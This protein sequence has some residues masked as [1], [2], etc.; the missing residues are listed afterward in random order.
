MAAIA[1][2]SARL[3]YR[4]DIDGLRAVAVLAVL[5]A[6]AGMPGVAGGFLGVDVFFVI[7]GYLITLILKNQL[8]R[9]TLSLAAFYERRA[10]RIVPALIPVMMVSAPLGV[11]LMLPEFRQNFGQSLVA[12]SLFANNLLLTVTSGYWELESSFKPLLHTWSLGVE[13]Q[14]Y[15]V[16]PILLALVWKRGPRAQ[17]ALIA[18]IGAASFVAAEIGWRINPDAN[19]YLPPSRA[20]ELMAGCAAAYVVRK[21]RP[22]DAALSA[23]SLA[24]VIGSMAIFDEH[25][26]S[27][28][29]YSAV[30]VAG[31]VGIIVLNHTGS[32]ADRVLSFRPLVFVGLISYSAYL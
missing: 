7:S 24:A 3:S 21:P 9:S 12:T 18:A 20:W 4:S 26:P 27:P 13:E 5:F 17:L 10:R 11:W 29:I 2:E 8:A 31:A 28:S 30:P 16:F 22:Y 1:V 6:H 15:L 14:F 23:A 19:F 25:T 32:L